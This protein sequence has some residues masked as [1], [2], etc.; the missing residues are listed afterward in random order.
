MYKRQRQPQRRFELGTITHYVDS[1]LWTL[2]L[3]GG[4]TLEGGRIVT[5]FEQ[6]RS[7]LWIGDRLR[8]RPLSPL[9]ERA[10][11]P[12]RDALPTTTSDAVFAGLRYQPLQPGIA[13]GTLRFVEG[14]LDP[15]TV[16]PDQILVLA[17]LPD[18][19]PVVGGVISQ[20]LQAPLGH[21][22]ILC[23]SRGTPN[24]GL[25]GA[26]ENQ[27]LRGLEGQLVRL[28]IGSQDFA[29]RPAPPR[30]PR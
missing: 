7:A 12:F 6:L 16:R 27:T 8:F 3:I 25:R 18:E 17:Q 30:C 4:D 23:A 24:M 9:H 15:S 20:Q 1:D 5:L 26:I 22:A 11:A 29:V 13:F 19:I 28:E 10:I 2:E 21:I 14:P